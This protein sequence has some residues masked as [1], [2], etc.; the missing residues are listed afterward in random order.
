MQ[1]SKYINKDHFNHP[2]AQGL[3]MNLQSCYVMLKCFL[4]PR[5]V[6]D[7]IIHLSWKASNTV[8]SNTNSHQRNTQG[9]ALRDQQTSFLPT[10]MLALRTSDHISSPKKLKNTDVQQTTTA[11]YQKPLE[12]RTATQRRQQS[13]SHIHDLRP[14]SV[15]LDSWWGNWAC[16]SS[17]IQKYSARTF[18][19]REHRQKSKCKRKKFRPFIASFAFLVPDAFFFS[20]VSP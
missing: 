3:L 17:M 10:Q 12:L 16:A 7:W 11:T 18:S 14:H 2:V 1:H 20:K 5:T 8:S 19:L 9:T 15:N 4:W 6:K 13:M